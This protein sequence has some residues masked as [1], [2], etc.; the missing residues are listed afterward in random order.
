MGAEFVEFRGCCASVASRPLVDMACR[1]IIL[2]GKVRCAQ[3]GSFSLDLLD[4]SVA[5]CSK[6][7]AILV[8]L[9]FIRVE[10]DVV[11]VWSVA[12]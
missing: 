12:G 10:E 4:S 9:K 2:D 7:D 1:I 5:C 8:R 6:R 3:L 11:G